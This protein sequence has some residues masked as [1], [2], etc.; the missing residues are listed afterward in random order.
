MIS[1]LFIASVLLCCSAGIALAFNNPVIPHQDVP[2]PGAILYNGSYYIVTTGGDDK[3]NKFPIHVSKDLQTWTQIGFALPV[4]HLPSWVGTPDSDYWA[5]EIHI[6]A[7]G[8][9][10]LY[11]SAREK[12]SNILCIGVANA[13]SITGPY[14]GTAKP[15]IK[16][17]TVGS[18]DCTI[19]KVG[20]TNYLVWKDDGNGNRP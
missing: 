5:P 6:I 7:D 1:K 17:T 12:P 13:D 15:L 2:D 14:I 9:F 4:T 19:L 16:Q 8:Q 20:S 10:H 11:F 18:I 3:G